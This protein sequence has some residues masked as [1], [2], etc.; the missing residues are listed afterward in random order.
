LARI[1]QTGLRYDE[2]CP[3]ELEKRT[4]RPV[5]SALEA[6]LRLLRRDRTPVTLE[7]LELLLLWTGIA[8]L[9]LAA[10]LGVSLFVW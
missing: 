7:A 8:G 10:G 9:C 1:R 2:A 6:E 5:V 3:I 4:S